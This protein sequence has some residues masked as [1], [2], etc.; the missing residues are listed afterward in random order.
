MLKQSA[1]RFKQALVGD[2]AFSNVPVLLDVVQ[3]DVSVEKPKN[4]AIV[5]VTA[6]IHVWI[7]RSYLINKL[8][9]FSLFL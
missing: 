4:F 9:I 5:D 6:V 2:R 3:K 7:S 1:K 8:V